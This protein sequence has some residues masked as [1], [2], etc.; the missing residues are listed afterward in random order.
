MPCSFITR[1]GD[2]GHFKVETAF[3]NDAEKPDSLI[4]TV[5]AEHGPYGYSVQRRQLIQDEVFEAVVLRRHAS[6]GLASC[7]HPHRDR[8][9]NVSTALELRSSVDNKAF[10]FLSSR[11]EQRRHEVLNRSGDVHQASIIFIG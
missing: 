2:G 4:E 9:R 10:H 3:M 6:S 1:N 5:A 7:D 11:L 8:E